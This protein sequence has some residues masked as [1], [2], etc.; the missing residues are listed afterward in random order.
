MFLILLEIKPEVQPEANDANAYEWRRCV[1][2]KA[3]RRANNLKWPCDPTDELITSRPDLVV[4]FML[5][6]L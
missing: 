1:H 6:R 3:N 5:M 4:S 2:A